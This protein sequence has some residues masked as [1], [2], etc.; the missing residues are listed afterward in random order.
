MT[1]EITL[2]GRITAIGGL[3]LKILGGIRSGVKHFIYPSENS[4]EFDKF[5]DRYNNNAIIK[6]IVFTPVSNISEVLDIVLINS[7]K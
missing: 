6:D 4:K 3:D 5:M 1:G 7:E 2:Q